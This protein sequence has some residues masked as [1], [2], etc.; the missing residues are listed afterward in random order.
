MTL[1]FANMLQHILVRAFD[2][3]QKKFILI[4]VQFLKNQNSQLFLGHIYLGYNSTNLFVKINNKNFILAQNR[5]APLT[6]FF[7][8]R[9]REKKIILCII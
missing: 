1:N 4:F 3:R 2:Y 5:S 9:K 6:S 7:K 8:K